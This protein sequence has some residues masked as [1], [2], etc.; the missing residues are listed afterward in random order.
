MFYLPTPSAFPVFIPDL[1]TFYLYVR[2]TGGLTNL[3]DNVCFATQNLVGEK[4]QF[5]A[6]ITKPQ[7]GYGFKKNV[8]HLK[9]LRCFQCLY[10]T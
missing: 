2:E 5:M 7:P 1:V 3:L 10:Q 4:N 9:G 6:K 8:K